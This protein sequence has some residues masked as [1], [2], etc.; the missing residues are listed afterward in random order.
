MQPGSDATYIVSGYG[1]AVTMI[2]N[3][4]NLAE[5]LCGDGKLFCGKNN[6]LFSAPVEPGSTEHSMFIERWV[7]GPFQGRIHGHGPQFSRLQYAPFTSDYMTRF[8]REVGWPATKA[9]RFARKVEPAAT[10]RRLHQVITLARTAG[11]GWQ[12][13]DGHQ[14]S[15]GYELMG[16]RSPART[17]PK[18]PSVPHGGGCCV[19]AKADLKLGTP[20]VLIGCS[21]YHTQEYQYLQQFY[22]FRPDPP[23]EVIALSDPFCWAGK[24]WKK[25]AH[26]MHQ[27]FSYP[28]HAI[29]MTM[30]IVQAAGDPD[31]IIFGVGMNDCEARIEEMSKRD[32]LVMLFPHSQSSR[33]RGSRL[34]NNS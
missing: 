16:M 6:N 12:P 21:H 25:R 24:A 17:G 4:S 15:E 34:H 7:L 27:N 26:L 8:A 30:S 2:G 33:R 11:G 28:C 3:R 5:R 18:M 29:Q 32:I 19:H 31:T 14:S 9:A 22:A 10:G 23:F 20:D 1:L 13:E